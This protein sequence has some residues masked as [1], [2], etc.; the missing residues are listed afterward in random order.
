MK[1]LEKRP[2]AARNS[3]RKVALNNLEQQLVEF[4]KSGSVKLTRSGKTVSYE[5]EI[6][7]MEK[8]INTLKSRIS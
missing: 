8:E 5:V 6:N 7:R 4:K 2:N 1:K 3:R